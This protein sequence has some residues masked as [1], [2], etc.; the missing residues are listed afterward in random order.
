MAMAPFL[1]ALAGL[2]LLSCSAARRSSAPFE[3]LAQEFVYE[4]LA[5]SP[6]AATQAGYH[7]HAG[8]RLDAELDDFS[9]AA[10]ERQR[11]WLRDMRLRLARVAAGGRL[12]PEQ[13]VDY[14]ILQDQIALALLEWDEIQGW[15]HNPTLYVELV[16]SALYVPF[17]LEY[18]DK[19]VRYSHIIQRLQAIPRLAA[20]ARSNLI[21]APELWTHVAMEENQGNLS[22]IDT[23]LRQACPSPQ[24]PAFDAAAGPAL[25]ALQD[26]NQFFKDTLSRRPAD[27]RLGP[28][29]YAQ[30]FR[31]ASATDQSPPQILAAAEA[32]MER[33]RREM[34][35]L[36]R[37]LLGQPSDSGNGDPHAAIR[38]ALDQIAR[39]HATP[40]T[41]F[42][43]AQSDLEE[44]RAF[45]RQKDLLTLPSHD[46][47]KV[48]ETPE[49]MRGIYS[50]GGFSSAPPLEPHLGAFYWLTPIPADWPAERVESKLREYNF[51]AL[52][53][54]TIHEAM[55]GHY[56]QLEYA[57]QVQPPLRRII[58][59]LFGNGPYIEGWAVYATE[60]MLDQ[61]YLNHSPELRLTFLKQQL[62][63][64]ANAILDVRL[65]TL[66]MTDEQA[67]RLMMQDAFQERE[68]AEGKLQRAKL[69]SAQLPT[70]FVGWRDW[71]RLRARVQEIEGSNFNL[72]QFHERALR[73]GAV[74]LPA[75][76]RLL[77]GQP[78]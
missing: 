2:L 47:L 61:G 5:N 54:L 24:R 21:S 13:R 39:R 64:F 56:V 19:E 28:Q 78:L 49:F 29:R 37:R 33:T 8:R 48:I 72:K 75:L 20:Q 1:L 46:N 34:D 16:G 3:Q 77:T 23:L 52:K 27:W 58:R 11:R 40:Q 76:C 14:D 71:H 50:V 60:L 74:P 62:R 7:Q 26:L 15:R 45:V 31:F 51:Y 70:Y 55:P 25:R 44:A 69:S 10:I 63:V 18:A 43:A 41:Y 17:V 4:S 68:E 6:V 35:R 59:S 73:A 57:N 53:L 22:L 65:H 67:L 36:A 42:Q 32:E 38:Q 66:G 9:P 12:D 30:K